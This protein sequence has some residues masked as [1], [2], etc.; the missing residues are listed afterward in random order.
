M[1]EAVVLIVKKWA[2]LK[3]KAENLTQLLEFAQAGD[4]L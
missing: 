2:F 3:S 1:K 4:T